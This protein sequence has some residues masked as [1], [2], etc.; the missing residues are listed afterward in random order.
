MKTNNP[1]KV[2]LPMNKWCS[3][4]NTTISKLIIG[5]LF[6]TFNISYSQTTYYL[7][8]V[9]FDS[10]AIATGS[11]EYNAGVYSNVNI[12]LSNSA[13]HGTVT[14]TE[15]TPISSTEVRFKIPFSPDQTGDPI[16][17]LSFPESLD[18]GSP[19]VDLNLG[20]SSYIGACLDANCNAIISPFEN[21]ISGSLTRNTPDTYYLNNV[22]FND[23]ATATG[24]FD[25]NPLGG[26]V[27]YTNINI[28]ISNSP[29]FGTATFTA[30]RPFSTNPATVQFFTQPQGISVGAPVLNLNFNP[31]LNITNNANLTGFTGICTTGNCLG[32][33]NP[34]SFISSGTVRTNTPPTA[35]CTNFTVALDGAGNANISVSNIDAGSTD[36]IP[37]FTLSIDKSSFTCTNLGAN[38]VTLT[39]TDVN[40]ATASCQ[41]T[42]TVEDTVPPVFEVFSG[43]VTVDNDLGICGANVTVPMPTVSDNCASYTLTNNYT[44]TSDASGFYPVGTTVV[45]WTATDPSGNITNRAQF[46][47]VNDVEPASITCP[48]DVVVSTD[49]GTCNATVTVPPPTA[50]DNCPVTLSNSFNDTADASGVYPIGTTVVNWSVLEASGEITLCSQNITVNDT[51]APIIS[52]SSDVAVST[53]LGVCTA[54]VTVP[55][56]TVT[57]NCSF[58]LTNDITNSADASGVYPLGTTLVTWTATDP[59]GNTSTCTQTIIVN[60]TEGPT[61]SCPAD[62]AVDCGATVTFNNATNSDGCGFLPVPAS[63]PNAVVLGTF[64]NSTY[65][66]DT[67]NLQTSFA[68]AVGEA[69]GYDLVTINTP[70][71]NE[72][73]RQQMLGVGVNGILLGYNDITNEG[74]FVWQ[75]QQ[76]ANYENWANS[77]PSGTSDDE[78]YVIMFSDG[79]WYDG[80][81]NGGGRLVYEVHDYSAG[82]ILVSGVLSGSTVNQTTVNT[83]FSKDINGNSSTCTQTI[84]VTDTENPIITCPADMSISCPEVVNYSAPTISDNCGFLAVPNSIPN[85]TLLGTFGNS[86]YFVGNIDLT[87]S[88]AFDTAVASSYDLV[89]ISSSEENEFIR[90]QAASLGITVPLLLG[91]ND[92]VTEGTFVWQSGQPATYENWEPGDPTGGVIDEDYVLSFDG[93]WFDITGSAI[94]RIVYEVHDYSSGPIQVTGLPS[95]S[96]I[97]STT[98]NTF[99]SKDISGNVDTCSFTI[100]FLNNTIPSISCPSDIDLSCSQVVTYSAPTTTDDCFLTVPNAVPGFTQLGVFGDSTYF[101]SDTTMTPP[102]AFAM[103][104]ENNFDLLTINSFEENRYIFERLNS[105]TIAQAFLGY[106]D[107]TTE[108]TYTWQSQQPAFFENF[109]SAQSNSD[110]L[111]YASISRFNAGGWNYTEEN[112]IMNVIIEFH[113]YSSGRPI[114]VTGFPSGAYITNNIVNTFFS[115]DSAGNINT[116]SFTVTVD[117]APPTISCPSD[118]NVNTDANACTAVVSVPT[119]TFDDNCNATL[120]PSTAKVTYNY[121]SEGGLIDTPANLA[122]ATTATE[123]VLL[124]ITISGDHGF[125]SE[126][127]VLTGPDATTILDVNTINADCNE[128]IQTVT[129][130]MATWNTWVNT[131]GSSLTFTLLANGDVNDF[132]DSFFQIDAISL[133]NLFLTNDFNNTQDASGAYPI[134]TTTV[135]WAVTD[136]AGNSNTCLQTITVID[137][138]APVISCP[139][140]ISVNTDSGLCTAMVN[141]SMPTVSDNC[142]QFTN[143]LQNVLNNFNQFNQNITSLIPNVFNFSMDDAGGVNGNDI[144]DGGDDMY[145][146]GNMISTDLN[147]GSINYSDN[148][149]I[150]SAAFGTNGVFFTRK[151]DNMWLL[152]ANLDNVNS[153]NIN[154]NLGADSK[155]TSLADGF[156]S[157]ITVAGVNYNLF[158]K[159]VREEV[160]NDGTSDPSVNHLIIIPENGSAT[161]NFSN[162]TD[163]DQHQVTGLSDTNRLYYLLFASENSGLVD[164]ATM[165]AIATSF[166]NNVFTISNMAVQT[167]GLPS[168]SA[169]PIG[170]TTNTF[171]ATDE[172]GNKSMCS[173]TVTVNDTSGNCNV[174]VSPKAYLQGSALNST[175]ATDGLM[176]DDLRVGNYIPLNTPYSD[177]ATINS[178][179]LSATGAD[180]IVD[181]VWAELRDATANTA[182][183]EGKSALL[184]RDG[185][186]VAIDGTSPVMFGQLSGDYYIAIKHRNHLGIMSNSAIS[187]SSSAT[188]VDFTNGSTATFGSHAQT[189]FGM[190]TGIQG[191]WSGNANGD[192]EVIFLNTGAESVEVKQRV[193]DVSAVESPFGASV[194]YKPQGY[195]DEDVNLDGQVIFLNAGNELIPI[196]DNVLNHPGNA[197]FNSLFYKILAQLP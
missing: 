70:E 65:F 188:V 131:Y 7:N 32:V 91:Y 37:G 174:L 184:Q 193:L 15:F 97:T 1:L 89:T 76:P 24:S 9:V 38:T 3:V 53:D 170:T 55:A 124:R 181:W 12:Q 190:P 83:F 92:L 182:I 121:S 86:T 6:L 165:E 61:L 20:S 137:T 146:T 16:L 171:V 44:N 56:P 169:F 98:T 48:S 114:Q 161:Q 163:D 13:N 172:S 105:L 2:M 126:S 177:G 29:I 191:M 192:S 111:D 157:T 17:T 185:D 85:T 40:G 107:V 139:A 101:V 117:N 77:E 150:A 197:V 45:I 179:V 46:I 152:A 90:Q 178:S 140:D 84:T 47:N 58:T 69:S 66:I 87:A 51:E 135:T 118:I 95:G 78:D 52:C 167:T 158:V 39:V 120:I 113:N 142:T 180:A 4:P 31:A 41:A 168:G 125:Q 25:Y 81:G 160:P 30:A 186:I 35:L 82:A 11:F 80:P 173:F 108:G 164:N 72:Y 94:S 166:V 34:I 8:N 96:L 54:T 119:P 26:V 42:V 36:D 99:F 115:K 128:A 63:I 22:V 153:F 43:G 50:T 155:N 49:A 148:T 18:V 27:Q 106:N 154:G 10:G 149:V 60:D 176:R 112:S 74:S 73:L 144:R 162:N 130:P 156:T 71:E 145:D 102:L 132:C 23:G 93:E 123:D 122:N 138:E 75:S 183:V 196:K 5:L 175:I 59:S 33:V 68:F 104:Q 64:G 14:L 57:D 129:I 28:T 21:S 141:Y 103:A 116:C 67:R 143:T 79:N 195:Y 110:N 109:D 127:F 88:V 147:A 19:N 136:L 133:G 62:V 151:V 159:R 187:L 134:G 194:F 100:N 189:S